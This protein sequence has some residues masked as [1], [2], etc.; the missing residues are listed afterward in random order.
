MNDYF[1]KKNRVKL[2]SIQ[3]FK[4]FFASEKYVEDS[5]ERIEEH[6]LLRREVRN[7]SEREQLIIGYKFGAELSNKDIAKIM[8]LSDT[9]VGVILHRAIR[10]LRE[11]MGEY[12]G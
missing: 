5:I 8:E 12:Y 1:R 7:L 10:T 6:E 3:N 2:L 9:N 11:K 4:D